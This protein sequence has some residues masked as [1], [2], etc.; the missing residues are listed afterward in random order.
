M[1]KSNGLGKQKM[2][3]FRRVWVM[4]PGHTESV[5]FHTNTKTD[6]YLYRTRT[7]LEFHDIFSASIKLVK[8]MK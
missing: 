8:K 5:M 1:T 3:V 7:R 2:I 4:E 6:G